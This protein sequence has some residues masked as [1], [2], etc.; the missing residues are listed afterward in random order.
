MHNPQTVA[1]DTETFLIAPGT[2]SPPLVVLSYA[3]RNAAGE[4]ETGLASPEQAAELLAGWMRAGARLVGHN[5]PFDAAIALAEF[6]ELRAAIVAHFAAGL[7]ADTMIREQLL[8]I[9]KGQFRFVEVEDELTGEVTKQPVDYNLASIANRRCGLAL[10]KSSDSWR[11]RYAELAD[12]PLSEWPEAAKHYSL[13]D[14]R[15]TLLVCESQDSDDARATLVDE[16]AQ[17]RAFM[18]L[19][20]MRG[21]GVLVDLD[22]VDALERDLTAK[23]AS[24]R[25]ALT[26]TGIYRA[27]GSRNMATLRALV[28][29]A[30][31]ALGAEVPLTSGGASGNREVQTSAAV[32]KD[33]GDPRL[34]E[35]ASLGTVEKLL[36]AFVPGLRTGAVAPL[37]CRYNPLVESGRT[38]CTAERVGTRKGVQLQQLPRMGGVREAFVPRPG[39]LLCSVDYN[40]L[41]LR[42]LAQACLE[43][44]GYSTMADALIAEP[45]YDL[46]LDL[47]ASL[48][49]ALYSDFLARKGEPEVAEAR[50]RAKPVNFGFPGGLGLEKFIAFAWAQY[51][52]R[53][54]EREAKAARDAWRQRWP[55]VPELQRMV[56]AAIDRATGTCN[57]VQLASKRL[58]GRV[59]YTEACNTFFQGLAADG[60]KRAL[61]RVWSE[62]DGCIYPVAF[63]HDE[64]LAEVPEATA[65]EAAELL[66]SLMIEAMREVI[67]SVPITAEPALMRRWYK[68]AKTVRDASGRLIAWE[69]K[70]AKGA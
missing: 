50:Q 43:L 12:V 60:A 58:R 28:S 68:G 20:A 64:I 10:D 61:W 56:S 8:D 38:S 27:D 6:P 11:L 18:A 46:H 59:R 34:V 41:E 19:Q 40:T 3:L 44:V 1:W 29:S 14:A 42:A 52:V 53:F 33:S 2:A 17:V 66:T 69:P 35:L 51:G 4:V 47:A 39:F 54:S 32:L 48:S 9:A 57:V 24:A 15:A 63:L 67:P 65:H 22:V 16:P 30:Y 55:E 31:A 7:F 45:D 36:N 23:R 70:P 13:E 62:G 21:R 26:G 5:L 25:E 37:A 49:G